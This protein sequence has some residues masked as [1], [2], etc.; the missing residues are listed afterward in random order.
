MKCDPW[1][2]GY[3]SA[4]ITGGRSTPSSSEKAGIHYGSCSRHA[5]AAGHGLAGTMQ[6]CKPSRP[7]STATL[8]VRG[9]TS[10]H[11]SH[12]MVLQANAGVRGRTYQGTSC[13]F[14]AGVAVSSRPCS[15]QPETEDR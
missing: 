11:S 10:C 3:R 5:R 1:R 6:Q 14:K 2:L 12:C 13:K 7:D 9:R 15:M 4:G 8:G